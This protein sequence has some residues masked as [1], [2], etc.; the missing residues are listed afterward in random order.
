MG[1][2]ELGKAQAAFTKDDLN[3][4]LKSF[5]EVRPGID[6][7]K[8][9]VEVHSFS[10]KGIHLSVN[11]ILTNSRQS[12]AKQFPPSKP[13][14]WNKEIDRARMAG[15]IYECPMAVLKDFKSVINKLK[16]D[17]ED[18]SKGIESDIVGFVSADK[19]NDLQNA[20]EEGLLDGEWIHEY[21]PEFKKLY[22]AFSGGDYDEPE[23]PLY[24]YFGKR[25]Y[26]CSDIISLKAFNEIAK[27]YPW[28]NL[29]LEKGPSDVRIGNS[30]Q[31]NAIINLA[32]VKNVT[33]IFRF[34]G[35]DE[36]G[37][38]IFSNI[39]DLKLIN[40]LETLISDDIDLDGGHKLIISVIRSKSDIDE[41]LVKL[42]NASDVIVDGKIPDY[43]Y[44]K[45][46]KGI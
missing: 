28:L 16:S 35:S 25:N 30:R 7:N 9:R 14:D 15:G 1:L 41:T 8:L 5:I 43:V 26:P 19:L 45:G 22:L 3:S 20:F 27:K 39:K 11:D 34:E 46:I 44:Y 37:L 33:L 12:N 18:W 32:S 29:K 36:N 13:I 21:D 6:S 2:P 40:D 17:T 10:P 31:S 42:S 4:I 38:L 23:E 24:F